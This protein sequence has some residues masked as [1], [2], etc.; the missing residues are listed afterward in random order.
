MLSVRLLL[1]HLLRYER[2]SNSVNCLVDPCLT[3][4]CALYP[5][6]ECVANYCGGCWADYYLN[7]E[8]VYCESNPSI[9]W[10]FN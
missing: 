1:Y 2:L 10:D 5:D 7:N 4:E 6:A 8:L 9:E 3:S